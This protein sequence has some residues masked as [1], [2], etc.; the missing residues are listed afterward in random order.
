MKKLYL[1][2]SLI[3]SAVFAQQGSLCT[4]PIVI[5]SLPY[6][7]TDNTANYG[8]NYDPSTDSSPA[9]SM[10]TFGN[11]YHGG[12]D[13]IYSYTPDASGTIKIELP[14]VVGW[15]AMFVYTSCANIGVSYAACATGTSAGART[16]NNFAVTAGQTYYIF[17]SSWPAPQ[18]IAYTL[19]V[20]SLTLGVNEVEEAKKVAIYPNPVKDNLFFDTDLDVKSASVYSINGQLIKKASVSDNKIYVGDLQ[21]G[22]Y[23]LNLESNDGTPIHRK[24]TK[25]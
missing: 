24:F 10:T 11:N 5:T 16:I 20:T 15:S 21:S 19:N 4:D 3:S 7:T 13:V 22:M 9:C 12:N 2:I 1:I 14:S 8:D 6:T 25:L 23:I 17:I 18:T